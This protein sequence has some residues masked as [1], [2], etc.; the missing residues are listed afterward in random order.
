MQE[1]LTTFR[2]NVLRVLYG[3]IFLY[4]STSKWPLLFNHGPWEL[5]HGV[6]ITLLGALGLLMAFGLRYPVRMLPV[7][8]FEFL[9]KLFWLLSVALPLW[10]AGSID[11]D[12][13]ETVKACGFGVIAC[14]LAI[15]WG[16]VWRNYIKAPGDRWKGPARV[17]AG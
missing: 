10:R 6:A 7:M 15:P 2:L 14:L 1:E 5:M 17:T 3:M 8:L 13:M 12:T 9:W 16:F 4:L 11:A